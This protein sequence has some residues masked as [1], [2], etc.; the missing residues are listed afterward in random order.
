MGRA[1]RVNIVVCGML[2]NSAHVLLGDDEIE[3]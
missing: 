3:G 1:A 2:W